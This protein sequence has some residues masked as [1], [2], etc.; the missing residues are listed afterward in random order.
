M[1]H[2]TLMCEKGP[3]QRLRREQSCHTF[4]TQR[5]GLESDSVGHLPRPGPRRRPLSLTRISRRTRLNGCLDSPHPS[6]GNH[7]LNCYSP[8]LTT[9]L[10]T[11]TS[12]HHSREGMEGG[13]QV[14]VPTFLHLMGKPYPQSIQADGAYI[15]H[16]T[17]ETAVRTHERGE[18]SA[19]T[20][21]LSIT[22]NEIRHSGDYKTKRR[23]EEGQVTASQIRPCC[24]RV[25]SPYKPPLPAGTVA[26]CLLSPHHT[27]RDESR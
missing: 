15:S 6:N 1:C 24:L 20:D 3:Q 18:L 5:S 9:R 10:T 11:H 19:N 4:V 2:F 8:C 27:A 26:H 16:Q 25:S 23:Q 21:Q 22:A 14:R 12:G 13:A 7:S 17:N